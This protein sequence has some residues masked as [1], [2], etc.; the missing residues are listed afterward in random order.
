M[1]RTGR[2]GD[3]G[4]DLLVDKTTIVQCKAHGV[5]VAPAVA[6]E[7]LG[8]LTYSRA[9][10]AILVSM[11]RMGTRSFAEKASIQLWDTAKLISVQLGAD[12]R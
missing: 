6:R 11:S 2:V 10:R 3:E 8:C 4:V 5:P 9:A 1:E 7:L 12:Q